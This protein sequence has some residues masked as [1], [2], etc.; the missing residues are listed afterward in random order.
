[1]IQCNTAAELERHNLGEFRKL[2]PG[3]AIQ[4]GNLFLLPDGAVYK[5]A[6]GMGVSFHE[7]SD[8]AA[9]NL[10]AQI[11]YRQAKLLSAECLFNNLKQSLLGQSFG[12]VAWDEA[13][14]PQP[15][16]PENA[17]D[18]ADLYWL[19]KVREVFQKTKA[20]I[21]ELT[22]EYNQLPEV[23]RRLESERAR[24]EHEVAEQRRQR[25]RIDRI[26]AFTLQQLQEN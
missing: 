9:Q 12:G 17:Q 2:H 24:Q 6:S 5:V 7:P 14:G 21:A 23:K 4:T 16:E 25:E 15:P 3:V 13:L 18:A 8:D 26:R 22:S 1:M 11:G 19:V 10:K 20:E